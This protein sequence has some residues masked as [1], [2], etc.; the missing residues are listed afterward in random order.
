MKWQ[1]ISTWQPNERRDAP[2]RLSIEGQNLRIVLQYDGGWWI[3]CDSIG[4]VFKTNLG[5]VP[6]SVAK[7]EAVAFVQARIERM[8][9]DVHQMKV[10]T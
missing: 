1:D 2:N 9:S 8:L 10:A 7:V 6:L 5:D 3:R 4:S